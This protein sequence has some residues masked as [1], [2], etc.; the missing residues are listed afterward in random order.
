MT[1]P[2]TF[3]I[4]PLGMVANANRPWADEDVDQLK[5]LWAEGMSA[6]MVAR[7]MERTRNAIIGKVHRMGLASR[8]TVPN[9]E[10]R[11]VQT[12][13]DTAAKTSQKRRA[14]DLKRWADRTAAEVL[15]PLTLEDGSAVT[16]ETLVA[17]MC[18]WPVGDP[19]ETS[20]RFCGHPVDPGNAEVGVS[21]SKR[22][23]ASHRQIG[24]DRSKDAA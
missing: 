4:V 14:G 1:D 12:R 19:A 21:P 24:R 11:A 3:G 22:Y 20:F 10:V 16:L 6:S 18:K 7:A 13:D 5:A 17:G 15:E 8:A 2:R 9:R 23:C